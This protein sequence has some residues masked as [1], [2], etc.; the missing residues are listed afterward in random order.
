MVSEQAERLRRDLNA[1]GFETAFFESFN[2]DHD[3]GV[4][5]VLGE[6]RHAV[7]VTKP[8]GLANVVFLMKQWRDRLNG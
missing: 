1:A 7:R 4:A 2:C 8:E 6:H 3:L 5:V